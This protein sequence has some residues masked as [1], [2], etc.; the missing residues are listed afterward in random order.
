M[1]CFFIPPPLRLA[2]PLLVNIE[3]AYLYLAPELASKLPPTEEAAA[4]YQASPRCND[5]RNYIEI[6]FNDALSAGSPGN[7]TAI[8]AEAH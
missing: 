2:N 5:Q 6:Q 1:N 4:A 3:V 7:I 8:L